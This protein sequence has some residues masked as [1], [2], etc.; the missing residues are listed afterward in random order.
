VRV[1]RAPKGQLDALI[2]L[3]DSRTTGAVPDGRWTQAYNQARQ[4]Q[5]NQM[6]D[7]N[8]VNT[9]A[10]LAQGEEAGRVRQQQNQEYLAGQQGRYAEIQRQHDETQGMYAKSNANARIN[11]DAR[12]TPASDVVDFALDQQ[13]VS[14]TGGTVKVPAGYNQV[15]ANT[16]GQYFLTNDL[17]TNPNGSLNGTWTQQTEVHGNGNPY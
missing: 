4:Q 2:N 11:M 6:M 8:R 15:W 1:L 12:H 3:I 5:M 13:T 16:Q 10:M 17:N 7:Q 9:Q 14:G